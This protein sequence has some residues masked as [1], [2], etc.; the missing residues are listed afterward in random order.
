MA[1]F[2]AFFDQIGKAFFVPPPGLE[3][4]MNV[5][6]KLEAITT[7][8]SLK[9]PDVLRELVRHIEEGIYITN[10]QGDILD[11]NPALLNMLGVGSVTELRALRAEDFMVRPEL[12]ERELELLER[13]GTVRE[14]EFQIRSRDGQIR[15]VLDT[16][17]KARDPR[18]DEVLY[19][20]ILVDITQRK[21]LEN[22][23]FELSIRDPLTGCFNRRYLG[24]F[25]GRA[26]KAGWGCLVIDVDH[27]K[28]YNDR[29]GHKAGD[30]V[31]VRL[32]RLLMRQMRAEEG[33][34]RMG[35][36]EFAVLLFGADR[37]STEAAAK[38]VQD[39]G[40][41]QAPCPFSLGW[42]VRQGSEPLERTLARADNNMFAVRLQQRQPERRRRK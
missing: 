7:R 29:H 23:L 25:E 14:Y 12:R 16:A 13:K 15:T 38:R 3:D 24:D 32:S 41:Q 19:R 34:V 1:P 31:L 8:A 17:H 40:L 10:Q 28:L 39:A 21:E 9:D 4:K 35:G 37:A 11:A 33:V 20:G 36:D 2:R 22:Q 30:A 18:T 6:K 27:F 5:A 42:A 26:G